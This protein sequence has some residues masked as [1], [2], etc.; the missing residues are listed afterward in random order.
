MSMIKRVI[1]ES[2]EHAIVETAISA[3]K[4][5][6]EENGSYDRFEV[7]LMSGFVRPLIS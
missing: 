2:Y 5:I 3:L 7:D 4:Q 1:S 6:R